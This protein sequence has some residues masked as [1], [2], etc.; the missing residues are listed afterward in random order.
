MMCSDILKMYESCVGINW[1]KVKKII[2]FVYL[3]TC[4]LW[5]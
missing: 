1:T 5:N 4:I 3:L 2:I